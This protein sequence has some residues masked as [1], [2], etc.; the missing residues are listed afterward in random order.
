MSIA[1]NKIPGIYATIAW[2]EETAKLAK[3]HVNTNV[4]CIGARFIKPEL[5]KKIVKVNIQNIKFCQQQALY[6]QAL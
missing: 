3:Q 4:L 6:P 2:N 5:A 1:A